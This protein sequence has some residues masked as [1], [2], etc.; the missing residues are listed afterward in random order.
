MSI[1]ILQKSCIGCG[2]CSVV[3]PGSLIQLTDGKACI[4]Y[5]ERCWGC[6]S[7]IKECPNEAICFY[8]GADLGGLGGMLTVR[9]EKHLL[10]WTVK[11]PGGD[12]QTITVDSRDSNKY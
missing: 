12:L 8:L 4:K 10:H 2:K 1:E 6:T 5:P 7:C 3:C 11:K 9:Q